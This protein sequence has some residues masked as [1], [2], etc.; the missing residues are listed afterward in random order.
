MKSLF[1]FSTCLV[2]LCLLVFFLDHFGMTSILFDVNMY[3]TFFSISKLVH[4]VI[5]DPLVYK[6]LKN[7]KFSQ[8]VHMLKDLIIGLSFLKKIEQMAFLCLLTL[9]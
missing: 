6:G 5:N 2:M 4:K 9:A 1:T 7:P 8:L 3:G